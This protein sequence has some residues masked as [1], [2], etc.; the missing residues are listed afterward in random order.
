MR[1][2]MAATDG[3]ALAIVPASQENVV[4]AA[5]ARARHVTTAGSIA[6]DVAGS[7]ASVDA[8]GRG[9]VDGGRRGG[10]RPVAR[11]A[12]SSKRDARDRRGARVRRLGR[13]RGARHRGDAGAADARERRATRRAD[14]DQRRVQRES[15]IDARGARAAEPRRAQG[16][17]RVAILGSMLELGPH[18]PR[19]HDEIAREVLESGVE[20]IGALGEFGAAFERLSP[21]EIARRHGGGHR[22]SLGRLVVARRSRRRY[23]PQRFARDAPRETSKADHRLGR[24]A[25]RR[26]RHRRHSQPIADVL[27]A[28]LLPLAKQLKVLNVLTYISFRAVGG[29]GDGVAVVVRGRPDHSRRAEAGVGEPGSARRNAAIRTRGRARRRR[30]A[31]SSSSTAR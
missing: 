27:Y 16:K 30:W 31:G 7:D 8:D 25:E 21:R 20:L 17:Q 3:V 18:T 9:H 29:G 28:F 10:R 11:I 19:L 4:A 15:R 26:R 24:A 1:E 13:R 14:A 23:P 22:W 6:G 5:R 2:E 12:Q